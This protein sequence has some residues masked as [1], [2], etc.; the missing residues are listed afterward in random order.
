MTYVSSK[1][2]RVSPPPVVARYSPTSGQMWSRW[3]PPEGDRLRVDRGAFAHLNTNKRSTIVRPGLEA[4]KDMWSLLD[5]VDLVIDSPGPP[6][7]S[8]KAAGNSAVLRRGLG[9]S[10]RRTPVWSNRLWA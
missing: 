1:W 9:S 4:S 10:I 3:S 7:A 5:G 8:R 6:T 2:A